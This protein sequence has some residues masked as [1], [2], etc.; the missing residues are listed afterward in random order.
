MVMTLRI[1]EVTVEC[2][3]G[4]VFCGRCC[5]GTEMVLTLEDIERITSLGFELQRFAT[6][7]NGFMR[8]RNV[9]GHCIFLDPHSN[10]CTIYRWRPLGCRLYPLI[11]DPFKNK[12]LVDRLCPRSKMLRSRMRNL[13]R[14]AEVFKAL[15]RSAEEAVKRYAGEF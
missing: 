15:L 4:T 6:L 7:S 3:R 8:L 13:A 9:D 5:Y 12:V 11:Y 14:Y 10:R 2:R 1:P